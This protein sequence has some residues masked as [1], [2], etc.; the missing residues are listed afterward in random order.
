MFTVK[1]LCWSVTLYNVIM[2]NVLAKWIDCKDLCVI[3]YIVEC[4]VIDWLQRLRCYLSLILVEWLFILCLYKYKKVFHTSVKSRGT[5]TAS[6]HVCLSSCLCLLRISVC[7]C[8]CFFCLLL[9]L[10]ILLSFSESYYF[11]PSLDVWCSPI[12][13]HV[14]AVGGVT[15]EVLSIW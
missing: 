6:Q 12:V 1:W 3:R 10:L 5:H 8:T 2:Y 13:Y 11:S 9:L 14:P 4:E 7:L 15:V